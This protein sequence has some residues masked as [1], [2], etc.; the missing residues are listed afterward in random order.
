MPVEQFPG[1]A[2]AS[3]YRAGVVT[4]SRF[5]VLIFVVASVHGSSLK[6]KNEFHAAD[7]GASSRAKR[8][9]EV[10]ENQLSYP[11]TPCVGADGRAGFCK[12]LRACPLAEFRQD[13][14]LAMDHLCVIPPMSVG[15]CCPEAQTLAG[16]L[17][18]TAPR[19]ADGEALTRISTAESRGCG[20]STRASTRVVGARPTSVREWPW[21]ASVT[22]EGYEQYCGGVLITDR[23]VLTAA[24][25]TR[26]WKADELFV[27]LG[28][29]DLDRSDDTRT[30]N[31]RVVEI[32]QHAEFDPSN[33]HHDV[34]ILKL[35]R[36]AT[37]NSYV[38]P[39]CLPPPGVDLVNETAFIIGWGTQFFGGPHSHVLME[40]P[41]PVWEHQHCV[42]SFVDSIFEESLCAGA[43]EGGRD[44][45]QGDSGG[46]LMHQLPSGRWTV[47]G[48]VS[49]GVRCGEPTHPGIYAKVESYLNWI[50]Q[51]ARF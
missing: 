39:I 51:N 49:W 50:V 1:S 30:Y 21:M 27:R 34:A 25:C 45:C 2:T 3:C 47:V 11:E 26:R 24:H 4:M 36:P 41:V 22:P 15:V 48:V 40:V 16:D 37:F 17:P 20:V 23:H 31:F 13:A 38:W 32:R 33:Y 29:Y 43:Y 8:L 9:V 12:P 10:S 7:V 35:H 42:R 19:E 6:S 46:P 28:E 14:L 5:F 44:A 18:A